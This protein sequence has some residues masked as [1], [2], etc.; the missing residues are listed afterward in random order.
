MGVHML[1][2]CIH[3]LNVDCTNLIYAILLLLIC[4]WHCYIFT[5]HL[6]CLKLKE[7]VYKTKTKT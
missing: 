7:A 2:M 5:L 3:V 1:Y 4:T 6:T